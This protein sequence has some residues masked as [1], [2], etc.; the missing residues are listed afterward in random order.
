[1]DVTCAKCREPFE[2]HHM[3]HD[4]IHET[5]LSEVDI[6]TWL[7]LDP[8]QRLQPKYR[9]AFAALGWKFGNNI[10]NIL[11]CPYCKNENTEIAPHVLEARSALEDVLG[12]DVDG[13][14]VMLEDFDYSL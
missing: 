13:L 6:E 7:A 5:S 9:E 10:L 2:V 3:L 1:M 12:N 4:E 8:S 14:A 11:Q